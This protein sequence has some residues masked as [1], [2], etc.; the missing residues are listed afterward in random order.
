[1]MFVAKTRNSNIRLTFK[2]TN[3]KDGVGITDLIS[4]KILPSYVRRMVRKKKSKLDIS[5]IV[6]S[7]DEKEFTIKYVILTRGKVSK[8][9]LAAIGKSAREFMLS[10]ASK[11]S[12]KKIFDDV[13]YYSL[14]KDMKRKLSKV[15]PIG[16]FEVRF[17]KNK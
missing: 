8:A 2:V 7:K 14:Q 4:Y 13:I 5:H 10:D 12:S 1:M 11:K 16:L 15:Y 17:L 6:K 3:T 9:V